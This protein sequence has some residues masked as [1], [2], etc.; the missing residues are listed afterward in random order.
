[1]SRAKAMTGG[2]SLS[3][4]QILP[5]LKKCHIAQQAYKLGCKMVSCWPL[6]TFIRRKFGTLHQVSTLLEGGQHLPLFIHIVG[7]YC[8]W[9]QYLQGVRDV[10]NIL[11]RRANR[12]CSSVETASVILSHVGS[13]STLNWSFVGRNSLHLSWVVYTEEILRSLLKPLR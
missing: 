5:G 9:S 4:M 12:P 8:T 7:C 13:L 2:T 6:Y 11:Q 3:F 10:H 1:V